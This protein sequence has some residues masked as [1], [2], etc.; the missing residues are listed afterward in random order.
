M[1]TLCTIML[2]RIAFVRYFFKSRHSRHNTQ[3]QFLRTRHL[4]C[5]L[6]WTQ[7]HWNGIDSLSIWDRWKS[8]RTTSF[9]SQNIFIYLPSTLYFPPNLKSRNKRFQP[10]QF[11]FEDLHRARFPTKL[12]F[13]NSVFVCVCSGTAFMWMRFVQ[14]DKRNIPNW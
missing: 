11:Q 3:H 7:T 2:N 12:Y 4:L 14:S 13:L 6:L 10:F 9:K 8:L 1:C 5:Q